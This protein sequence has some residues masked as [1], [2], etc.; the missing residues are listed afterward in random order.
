MTHDLVAENPAVWQY[1]VANSFLFIVSLSGIWLMVFFYRKLLTDRRLFEFLGY[2]GTAEANRQQGDGIE[3]SL[4][5]RIL[6]PTVIFQLIAP[7][8]V[9]LVPLAFLKQIP[10]ARNFY[11][12]KCPAYQ[13]VTPSGQ[14][15]RIFVEAQ[16]INSDGSSYYTLGNTLTDFWHKTPWPIRAP[17]T[18]AYTTDGLGKKI[19]I[20]LFYR[21]D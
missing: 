2:S 12:Q 20:Q 3:R 15:G 5:A 7:L 14:C 10:P 21:L 9:I 16:L 19:K 17:Q 6:T 1:L 8:F 18:S 13:C 4:S 11:S